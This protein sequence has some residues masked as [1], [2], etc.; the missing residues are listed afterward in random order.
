MLCTYHTWAHSPCPPPFVQ[1]HLS[2]LSLLP[3]SPG[4]DVTRA[5]TCCIQQR[6]FGLGLT[7]LPSSIFLLT[8]WHSFPLVLRDATLLIFLFTTQVALS[9]CFS[10][11]LALNYKCLASLGF[12]SGLSRH[13]AHFPLVIRSRPSF[14]VLSLRQWQPACSNLS[15]DSTSL[16]SRPLWTYSL[17]TSEATQTRWVNVEG[18]N[19]KKKK[20]HNVRVASWVLFGAKSGP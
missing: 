16:S 6:L 1:P 14:H 8:P 7:W 20:E 19:S 12:G 2:G 15:P 18:V 17:Q 13:S 11:S 5:P 9:S 10:A 3:C 4:D